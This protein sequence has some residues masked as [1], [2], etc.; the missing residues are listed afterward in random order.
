MRR[1]SDPRPARCPRCGYDLR[2][3]ID[4][5][6]QQCPLNGRCT[7]CGLAFEWSEVMCPTKYEPGWCVEFTEKRRHVPTACVLTYF[8][9]FAPWVFWRR[10]AMSF[11][12]RPG[13]LVVYLGALVAPLLC[14]YVAVQAGVAIYVRYHTEQ[15]AM[16]SR[17]G[18]VSQLQSL[19]SAQKSGQL[20]SLLQ[21]VPADARAQMKL[22]WESEINERIKNFNTVLATKV[23]IEPTYAGAVLEAVL[24]PLAARSSGGIRGVPG[25]VRYP[26][27]ADLYETFFEYREAQTSRWAAARRQWLSTPRVENSL[28]PVIGGIAFGFGGLLVMPWTMI[29]LP[30]SRRR[31]KVQWRHIVRVSLYSVFI[32]AT[33]VYVA[34]LA[35]GAGLVSFWVEARVGAW[36]EPLAIFGPWIALVVWWWSAISRYLRIPHGFA[37]ALLLGILSFIICLT[38]VFLTVEYL[39]G[40]MRM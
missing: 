16:A 11:A 8:R 32:P 5:W 13:R 7:E 9:S 38:A 34:A 2:G 10:L 26:A 22:E 4:S 31:A 30:Q 15:A 20:N 1:L 40:G 17:Q 14:L 35:V 37:V 18:Y 21:R 33:I 3:T 28:E 12:L 39:L 23:E 25:V 36:I 24:F 29:L 19:K 6:G 27:P